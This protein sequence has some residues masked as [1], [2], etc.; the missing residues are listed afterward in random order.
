M[1]NVLRLAI[2][3]PNDGDRETLKATLMGLDTVWLEAECSRYAFFK[4]V[5]DQTNPDV[6]FITMDAD[7]EKAVE[8]VEELARTKPEVALLVA[9]SS[10]D[11]ALILRSMRAGEIG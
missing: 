1:S 5:V 6:A 7:P 4:D 2:V 10:T 9:S 3:D 11:R 8:L